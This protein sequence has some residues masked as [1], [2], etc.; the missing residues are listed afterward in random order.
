MHPPQRAEG[1]RRGV[2]QRPADGGLAVH[3]DGLRRA[4]QRQPRGTVMRTLGDAGVVAGILPF[5]PIGLDR[6]HLGRIGEIVD[7]EEGPHEF[8]VAGGAVVAL[9]RIL[10]DHL[11]VAV[12]DEIDLEGELGG[13]QSMRGERA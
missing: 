10:H 9:P 4:G 12:L 3:R 11:P 8:A 6:L 2:A 1:I 7:V 13:L 5:A